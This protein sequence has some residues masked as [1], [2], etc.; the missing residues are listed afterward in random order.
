MKKSNMKDTKLRPLTA[1]AALS[2]ASAITASAAIVITPD[3]VTATT[4][5]RSA[6]PISATIDGTGLVSTVGDIST[7]T[8]AVNDP[9]GNYWLSGR[10]AGK[11]GNEV[12]TFDLGGTFDVEGLYLWQY[13]LENS[14]NR[15]I[16]DAT[17]TFST[18]GINYS[19]SIAWNPA[20]VT[21][22]TAYTPENFTFT[23][24]EDVTHIKMLVENSS[25][26]VGLAEIRFSAVP[27][28]SA[29]LLSGF[30]LLGL[31]RRRR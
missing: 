31:L 12:I 7:W 27:E 15:Q 1:T 18:D 25:D 19:N 2:A 5:L 4:S 9:Q 26:F 17:L 6:S 3:S 30:A 20:L 29:A 28:P 16:V 21:T 13:T 24:V 23:A 22:S 11:N 14:T 8:H 10:N